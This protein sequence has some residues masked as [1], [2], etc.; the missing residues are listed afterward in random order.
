MC[1]TLGGVQ[2]A[3]LVIEGN[4][5]VL[6][7][8]AVGFGCG[9]SLD[10]GETEDESGVCLVTETIDLQYVAESCVR[11]GEIALIVDTIWLRIRNPLNPNECVAESRA[12]SLDVTLSIV[13]IADFA[14][15]ACKI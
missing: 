8:G 14:V 6:E 4:T 10:D 13:D 7:V 1:V 12:G 9:Q 5:V 2:V 3:H 15:T 11:E